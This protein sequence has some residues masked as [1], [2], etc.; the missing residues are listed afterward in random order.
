M[1]SVLICFIIS[2]II[3]YTT[4][5]EF[6]SLPIDEDYGKLLCKA[7]SGGTQE[8]MG[9][10]T[11]GELDVINRPLAKHNASEDKKKKKKQKKRSSAT[12][13]RFHISRRDYCFYYIFFVD[14]LHHDSVACEGYS[15]SSFIIL[16]FILPSLMFVISAGTAESSSVPFD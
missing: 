9:L 13:L 5:H 6:F 8:R 1:V 3:F 11:F 15:A 4:W 16:F 10:R 7:A 2:W 14:C 12:K